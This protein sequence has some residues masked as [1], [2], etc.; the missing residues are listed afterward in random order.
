MNTR[1][2]RKFLFHEL[3]CFW[4]VLVWFVLRSVDAQSVEG[5]AARIQ[6]K[7]VKIHGAGGFANLHAY[8]S[9]F[10]IDSSGL[11][12][13][14]RSHVLD[15]KV[16]VVDAAGRKFLAS[17]VGFDP[18]TDVALLQIKTD[19]ADHFD[20]KKKTSPMPGDPVLAFSNLFGIAAKNE[21]VSVM[22]GIVSATTQL[23]GKIGQFESPYS[24]NVHVLDLI[25]NNPGAG[26][27]AVVNFDGDLVGMIG[28]EMRDSS[29]GI[30]LNFCLPVQVVAKSVADIRSGKVSSARPSP[31]ASPIRLQDLGLE[32]IPEV[33]PGTRP[34]VDRTKFASPARIAGIQPDDLIVF[35]NR[36]P[37]RN[38]PE[39]KNV[40]SR[41]DRD[42]SIELTIRRGKRILVKKLSRNSGRRS[43]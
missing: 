24:G 40:F 18:I 22:R 3:A 34:Y 42:Q 23:D 17:F 36:Q 16:H 31:V 33:F 32:L 21:P 12:V 4:L 15:G 43:P 25:T 5:L 6:P 39:L 8:Q 9:G 13:T 28:R 11:I 41:I 2:A 30:W 10:L 35:V 26:G 19:D 29:T 20:L 7:M 37:V 38:I 1:T 14:V 27:G